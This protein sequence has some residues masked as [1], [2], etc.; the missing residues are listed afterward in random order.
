MSSPRPK[1]GFGLG[2]ERLQTGFH[3]KE[4]APGKVYTKVYF[5]DP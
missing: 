4:K 2:L 5:H 1:L 3:P